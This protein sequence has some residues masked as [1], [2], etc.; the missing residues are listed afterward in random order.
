VAWD[1][2]MKTWLLISIR[3]KKRVESHGSYWDS[4]VAEVEPNEPDYRG[5]TQKGNSVLNF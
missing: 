2:S 1:L 5:F 3:E 4:R